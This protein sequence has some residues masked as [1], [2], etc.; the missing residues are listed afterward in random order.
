M[1]IEQN[2]QSSIG[3]F[4]HMSHSKHFNKQ[5]FSGSVCNLHKKHEVS[6]KCM[7]SWRK[8]ATTD[9]YQNKYK[10]NLDAY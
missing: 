4:D 7:N 5:H 2:Y 9:L 3:G 8:F 10:I 6:L 1:F